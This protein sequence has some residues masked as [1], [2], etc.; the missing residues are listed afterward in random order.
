MKMTKI[1]NRSTETQMPTQVAPVR[2]RVTRASD[3]DG[4]ES[5]DN[6]DFVSAGLAGLFRLRCKT[7]TTVSIL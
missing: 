4:K 3:D 7:D 6:G 2:V 1:T 5:A